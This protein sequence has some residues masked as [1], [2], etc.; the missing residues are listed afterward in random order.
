MPSST[1]EETRAPLL[2]ESSQDDGNQFQSESEAVAYQRRVLRTCFATAILIDCGALFLHTP[3]TSILEDII[4][5]RHY[6]SL[7]GQHDCTVGPVQAELASVDQL[8]NTFSRLPGLIVAVPFGIMADRFGRRPV[9][10]LC[11]LGALLQDIASKSIL[12]RPDLFPPRLIWLSPAGTF[13]GGGEAVASFMVYLVVADV[14]PPAQR[15]NIFFLLTACGLLGEVIGTPLSA[16]LLSKDPW[17]P[18]CLY[19]ALTILGGIIPM[20]F[21]PETLPPPPPAVGD[22]SSISSVTDET[23]TPAAAGIAASPNFGILLRFE[24]LA[25]RNV[26]AVLL[27]FLVSSLGRQS[28]S[29]LLQYIRQRFNW[30]YDKVFTC[31]YTVALLVLSLLT[32]TTFGIGQSFNVTSGHRQ[33]CFAPGRAAISDQSL[34]Q[35]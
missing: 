10:L 6:K 26:L 4:C 13:V 31:N 11:I 33:P 30:H 2:P 3:Q 12:W 8:F 14:S 34:D 5:R 1:A 19:T 20:L 23:A 28:T 22:S 27:S 15:A 29:F 7:P 18:Y 35:T 32:G 21:L 16:F 17:I 24:P 9:L 25:H